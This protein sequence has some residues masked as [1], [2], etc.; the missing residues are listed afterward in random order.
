MIYYFLLSC[1]VSGLRCYTQWDKWMET[2]EAEA[3]NYLAF[4]DNTFGNRTV[5]M[6][7]LFAI[8]VVTWPRDLFFL[9]V[10]RIK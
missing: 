7:G 2:V 9:A 5:L 4:F 1:L 3:P 6:F 8:S 10:E